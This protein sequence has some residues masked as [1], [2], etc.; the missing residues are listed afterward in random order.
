M[1][2]NYQHIIK[3]I[4]LSSQPGTSRVTA[5]STLSGKEATRDIPTSCEKIERWMSGPEN[6][7]DV[8]PDVS[9]EDR[10]FLMTGITPEEWEAFFA[11]KEDT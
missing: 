11:Y 1:R 2:T 10:E 6:I 8:L 3:M 4:D 7:Q 9:A 5:R